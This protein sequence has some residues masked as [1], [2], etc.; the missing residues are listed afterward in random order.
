MEAPTYHVTMVNMLRAVYW[1]DEALQALLIEGGWSSI[2]RTQSLLFANIGMGETRP[3]R[4][5]RNMGITRQ[6]MSD[7]INGLVK[8]GILMTKPDPHDG[9]AQVVAFHPDGEAMV[10][11]VRAA[12]ERINHIVAD[13]IGEDRFEALNEALEQD[14]GRPPFTQD[15]QATAR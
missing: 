4:L 7:L 9:R 2:T 10:M 15:D 1:Y 5:A 11:A 13:R 3:A 14:W 8:R 6:S 12:F